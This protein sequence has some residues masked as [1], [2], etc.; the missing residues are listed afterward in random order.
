MLRARVLN[1]G[2]APVAAGVKVAFFDGASASGGTLLGVATVAE[3]L[4]VGTSAL[5]TLSVSAPPTAR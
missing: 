4:P 3:P 1:Q 5:A 2:E